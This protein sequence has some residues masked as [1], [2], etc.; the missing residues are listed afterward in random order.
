MFRAGKEHCGQLAPGVSEQFHR[1]EVVDQTRTRSERVPT[2]ATLLKVRVA[3]GPGGK[4]G[5]TNFSP[6]V[7]PSPVV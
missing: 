1:Q 7:G 5:I 3:S 6:H 2:L 4:H